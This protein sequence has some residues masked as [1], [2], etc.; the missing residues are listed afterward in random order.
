MTK[1]RFEGPIGG[2][3]GSMG[4]MVFADQKKKGRTLAYMKTQQDPTEAQLKR[5]A[6][7]LEASAWADDALKDPA[8]FA[9]YE[10]FATEQ[11]KATRNLAIGEF[12][13]KPSFKPLD[14]SEYRGQI[15]NP[16]IIKAKDVISLAEVNVDIHSQDGILIETGKA[17]QER[18]RS[19]EWKY[20]ATKQVALGSDVFIKIVGFNHVGTKVQITENPTVGAEE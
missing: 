19:W 5:K 10:K 18:F 9:F 7:F 14:L 16:I 1:V 6:C 13:C 11:G 17:V 8:T 4:K 20:T 12:L 15:G 2:F 3:S